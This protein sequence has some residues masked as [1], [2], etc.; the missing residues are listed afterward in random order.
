[1]SSM[2]AFRQF[3]AT[4]R[5]LSRSLETV[6][7]LG[8]ESADMDSCCSALVAAYLWD[9]YAQPKGGTLPLINI[10]RHDLRLRK[11]ICWLF[12]STGIEESQLLFRDD[13]ALTPTSKLFLVDHNSPTNPG[14]VVAVL[15]HHASEGAQTNPAPDPFVLSDCGSC[16][17][18]VV[19]WFRGHLPSDFHWDQPLVTLGL[20]PLLIDTAALTNAKTRPLDQEVAR[21]LRSLGP[22][23]D[24]FNVLKKQKDSVEGF[25]SVELLRKDYKQWGRLGISS[26]PKRFVKIMDAFPDLTSAMHQFRRE[27]DID[28]LLVAASGKTNGVYGRE[29]AILGDFDV[30]MV[31]TLKLHASYESNDVIFYDQIN[32]EASRK[33]IAPEF[34]RVLETKENT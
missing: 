34:R 25:S 12:Q 14:K 22:I 1:M 20:A 18:L 32:S 3:L 6:Y 26:L 16:M 33:Q 24:D 2:K 29:L 11:D 28:L 15:D 7:V 19:S 21:F 13:V 31:P 5:G 4:R 10:P 30:S 17:S 23:V 27:K 9:C 8:N